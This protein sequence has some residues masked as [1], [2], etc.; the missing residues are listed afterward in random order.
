M[1]GTIVNALAVAAGGIFGT[2]F[3]RALPE[4]AKETML[5]A[6][7]LSTVVIGLT[8]AAKTKNILVVIGSLVL[9]AIVGE[10]L[11]IEA[12]LE[13]L[14]RWLEKRLASRS[15]RQDEA[16]GDQVAKAFVAASL[17]YCV[18]SMAVVGSIES[19]LTGDHTILFAKAVIDGVSAIVFAS[20]MGFGVA[21]SAGSVF[22]YQGAITL[23]ARVMVSVLPAPAI[24]EL[25]ATG[26][27]MIVAI[28][29]NIL[30]LKKIRVG[31]LLPAL[32]FAVL[33]VRTVA[34]LA[35]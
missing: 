32:V 11:D 34:A 17:I 25:T 15:E 24:A 29:L 31:N 30:E 14:G 12:A 7:A 10:G 5:Q 18:G 22:V 26:G 2:V 6:L 9:G 33:I 35:H 8:M 1:L 13:R 3:R 20:A 4:K 28:G 27:V 19:G 21:L 23:L 16:S